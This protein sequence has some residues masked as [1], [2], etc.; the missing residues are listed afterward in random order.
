LDDYVLSVP[1]DKAFINWFITEDTEDKIT[2]VEAIYYC[3]AELTRE[4]ADW[5]DE[6]LNGHPTFGTSRF[7]M[8]EEIFRL[9]APYS[10]ACDDCAL[11]LHFLSE[12]EAML[13]K[14]RWF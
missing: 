11:E 13:F 6:T 7:M 3:N 14:L 8:T 1:K 5:C 9:T 4:V 2:Y 10:T 12:A